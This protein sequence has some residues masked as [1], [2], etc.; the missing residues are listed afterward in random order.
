MDILNKPV[1]ELTFRDIEEF[2][3]H[4]VIEGVQVDYKLDKPSKGFSKH[5]AAFSNSRGG[6]I[7]I[8]VEED[9][10][11]GRPVKWEGVE[12]PAPILESISQS[13]S[14][15]DPL[16]SYEVHS[17]S[18][19]AGDRYFVLVRIFE[20]NTTP[21]YVQNDS[22]LWVRTGS[23]AKAIDI[24]SPETQ[25]LLYEKRSKAKLLRENWITRANNAFSAAYEKSNRQRREDRE[26]PTSV[27]LGEGHA[28][29]TMYIQPYYPEKPL[30]KVT[31]LKRLIEDHGYYHNYIRFPEI[32]NIRISNGCMYFSHY[33]DNQFCSDQ[34]YS[35]GLIYQKRVISSGNPGHIILTQ[36]WT[37]AYIYAVL[38]FAR[39]YHNEVGYNGVLVGRIK[40]DGIKDMR[41]RP[42]TP[43]GY[44][45]WGFHIDRQFALLDSSY[46][47][48]SVDTAELNDQSQLLDLLKDLVNDIAWIFQYD[49]FART[50]FEDY[51]DRDL[52]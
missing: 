8:G 9:T 30:T 11:S 49:P 14:N 42:L 36:N 33:T 24:A 46:W 47:D 4:G 3:D 43:T 32:P 48:F 13:A 45:S 39:D 10:S 2:C 23:I 34:V 21:Y 26:N 27:P 25:A 19:E 18:N 35:S 31:N 37:T 28:V 12:D 16:P 7:I 50:V 15:V 38:K 41:S 44:P 29:M 20:G 52:P 22:N 5:F 6:I 17:P 1:R 51:K 40:L